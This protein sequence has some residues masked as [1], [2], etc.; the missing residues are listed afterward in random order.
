MRVLGEQQDLADNNARRLSRLKNRLLCH[1]K[2]AV[3]LVELAPGILF[4]MGMVQHSLKWSWRDL[5]WIGT[6]GSEFMIIQ[7]Y[8]S[9]F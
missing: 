9:P 5:V 8:R 6:S 4:M 3:D 2:F 1:L 7:L